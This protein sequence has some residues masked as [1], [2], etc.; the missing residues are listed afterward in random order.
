MIA[1]TN[2][3]LI[4]QVEPFIRRKWIIVISFLLVFPLSAAYA[5]MMPKS[6]RSTTLILVEQ[7]KVSE[8]Y[9]TPT[10]ATP[11]TQR[12]NT[13]SQ[14]IMS[15]TNL[16]SIIMDFNL[17]APREPGLKEK[18]LNKL[19]LSMDRTPV[20]EVLI[21]EMKANIEVNVHGRRRGSGDAFSISFAGKDPEV[22][23]QVTNALATMFIN[24]NLKIREQYAEGTTDFILGELKKAK[25]ELEAQEKAL[26]DFKTEH[27]GAL[28]EQLNA[29]LRT[30]D[31]LQLELQ[32]VRDSIKSTKDRKLLL[33]A[34]YAAGRLAPT[35]GTGDILF[36]LNE[37]LAGLINE[38]RSLLSLYKENYPDVILVR[39]QIRNLETRIAEEKKKKGKKGRTAGNG[40]S[41]GSNSELMMLE[42]QIRLYMNREWEINK[43]TR[44]Y[45]KRVEETPSNEQRLA[46]LTRDYNISFQNYQQLLEKK[47]SA[48]LAEN[49]EKRQKGEK[50]RV[51]D[52]ANLP[53]K[54]FKP[55]VKLIAAMGGALGIGLGMALVFLIELMNPAFRKAE[56]FD[57]VF[58]LPV[59]GQIPL[60]E[61][62]PEKNIK[63][64]LKV[65]NGGKA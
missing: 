55:N 35:A 54:P 40:V 59:L 13:I 34:Q 21:E 28:P 51:L 57:G 16:E 49:L 4:D 53:E 18:I 31:R 36:R 48:R 25:L 17:N 44:H 26:S 29:N 12:L 43:Q 39:E 33:E 27:M 10:D 32:S 8:Q 5:L 56:D 64:R 37:E 6:Y 47:L 23:R 45:E 24:A 22:T 20:M 61:D 62:K 11:I 63:S 9:V 38:E 7:Q 41:S 30:L 2:K 58:S 42:G 65:V 46:D 3:N 50:F 14:Q 60:F 1:D 19:G 52:P 15:R